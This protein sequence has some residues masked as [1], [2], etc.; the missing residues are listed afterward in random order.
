MR[1]HDDDELSKAVMHHAIFFET[2]LDFLP[3]GPGDMLE[4]GSG[5]GNLTAIVTKSRPEVRITALERDLSSI[6]EAENRPEL[7]GVRF[8][9]AD[10]REDWPAGRYDAVFSHLCLHQFTN[11]ERSAIVRHV[12]ASLRPGGVFVNGDMFRPNCTFAEAL[13]RRRWMDAMLGAGLSQEE[14]TGRLAIRNERF[15]NIDT[16]ENYR[17]KLKRAGFTYA[18]SPFVYEIYAVFAGFVVEPCGVSEE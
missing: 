3:E 5:V 1:M 11:Q 8:V 2:I 4:L 18:L 14:A 16:R 13:Y 15:M 12:I 17:K 7:S 10:I 9:Q 6:R